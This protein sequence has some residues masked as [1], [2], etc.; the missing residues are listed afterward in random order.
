MGETAGLK[1]LRQGGDDIPLL[2]LG[3]FRKRLGQSL[4]Y[5][6]GFRFWTLRAV[7]KRLGARDVARGRKSLF[8]AYRDR[9]WRRFR[10][11]R[12]SVRIP[13]GTPV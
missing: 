8:L 10:T 12:S 2:R 4:F 11:Q 7:P 9:F 13:L 6:V 5:G 1:L 3:G